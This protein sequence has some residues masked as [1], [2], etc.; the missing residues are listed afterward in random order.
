[1]AIISKRTQKTNK[2]SEGSRILICDVITHPRSDRRRWAA[3]QLLHVEE[4]G[5]ALLVGQQDGVR[6][7][8]IFEAVGP[9]GPGFEVIFVIIRTLT[10]QA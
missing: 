9:Q 6:R 8:R 5:E 7:Q 3:D 1:M 4:P 10:V 2:L